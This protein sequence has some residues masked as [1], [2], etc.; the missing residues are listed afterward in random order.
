MNNN[1][2]F[3]RKNKYQNLNQ[4]HN[5]HQA[6]DYEKLLY[7]YVSNK[8]DVDKIFHK[9]YKI[10]DKLG[11][12]HPDENKKYQKLS[13]LKT[14]DDIGKSVAVEASHILMPKDKELQY[15]SKTKIGEFSKYGYRNGAPALL[16]KFGLDKIL[17]SKKIIGILQ[18][19]FK[20]KEKDNKE[21]ETTPKPDI[22]NTI[23]DSV[24]EK[25]VNTKS[26]EPFFKF[27]LKNKNRVKTEDVYEPKEES[28]IYE[29][30]ESAE[31]DTPKKPNK[32]EIVDPLKDKQRLEK[33]I[34][35]IKNEQN[36]SDNKLRELNPMESIRKFIKEFKQKSE[37]DT[38]EQIAHTDTPLSDDEIARLKIYHLGF[39]EKWDD[40]KSFVSRDSL[41]NPE[42]KEFDRLS[43]FDFSPLNINS[44]VSK[45]KI[46]LENFQDSGISANDIF[47]KELNKV[48]I[49]GKTLKQ[50]VNEFL[51]SENY[52]SLPDFDEDFSIDTKVSTLNRI[53]TRYNFQARN[54]LIDNYPNFKNNEGLTLIQARQNEINKRISERLQN[55]IQNSLNVLKIM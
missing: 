35:D 34:S 25:P 8:N 29:R 44:L 3:K 21:I 45:S 28:N 32:K 47:K 19:I 6:D 38:S 40:I 18:S 41:N 55:N 9:L 2:N 11:I 26:K 36:K 48:T 52:N 1:Q 50:S 4:V 17:G 16:G 5:N 24:K 30:Y 43:Q 13:V 7:G 39:G 20:K 42:F 54:S 33:Q 23:D 53:F 12:E 15:E 27:T 10:A 51:T 14:L 22:N 31:K 49:N 37:I 46:D